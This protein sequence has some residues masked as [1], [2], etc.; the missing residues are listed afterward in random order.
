MPGKKYD[1]II[2]AAVK[3]HWPEV[4][5]LLI[6]A[7]MRAESTFNPA[8]R[9][10]CGAMGLMQLMPATAEEMGVG[11][12]FNPVESV[13]GG[14]KYLKRQYEIFKAEQGVERIKFA[15]GAYN[16]GAGNIIKAQKAARKAGLPT[17]RWDSI[18]QVLHEVTGNNALE[19]T[20]YVSKIMRYWD[21]YRSEEE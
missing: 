4:D 5:W 2:K 11:N 16:A 7:Q 14:V 15:L 6:K 17:D 18:A 12:P 20:E 10:D 3:A 9:S 19:T 8:A 21:E 13:N 1:G